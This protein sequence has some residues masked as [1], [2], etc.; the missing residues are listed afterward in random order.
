MT[1]PKVQYWVDNTDK[2]AIW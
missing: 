1:I 2:F